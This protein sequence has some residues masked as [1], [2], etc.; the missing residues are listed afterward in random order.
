[1][2]LLGREAGTYDLPLNQAMSIVPILQVTP[3]AKAWY[4]ARAVPT[5]ARSQ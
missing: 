4:R 5:R 2:W 1:M 3:T